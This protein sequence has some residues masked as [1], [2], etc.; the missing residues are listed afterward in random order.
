MRLFFLLFLAWTLSGCDLI[1]QL[2]YQYYYNYRGKLVCRINQSS[3]NFLPLDET[4]EIENI[5]GSYP[6]V[7]LRE[8]Q[9]KFNKMVDEGP[10]VNLQRLEPDTGISHIIILQKQRGELMYTVVGI[11]NENLVTRTYRAQCK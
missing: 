7:S 6:M 1:D 10:V 5:N 2:K 9:F 8:K 3:D 4:I 11:D